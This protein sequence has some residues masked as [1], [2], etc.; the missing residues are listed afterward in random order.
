MK[1][2]Y[3]DG[4]RSNYFKAK[5]VGDCVTRAIANATGLNYKKVY[6]DLK[7]L[8]KNERICKSNK[9]RSSVRDGVARK[10]IKKYL[11]DTLHLEW[12]STMGIGTG[13]KVHLNEN[14]LPK[15]KTII[16]SLSR[17]LTCVKNGILYDTYD[18]SRGGTRCV[19]GYWVVE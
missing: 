18:C 14:E 4:G 1:F 6:S 12:I 13:C 15:D 5:N 2:I 10:T 3:S 16:L 11:E 9:T 19:Y 17:H 8:A 7:V